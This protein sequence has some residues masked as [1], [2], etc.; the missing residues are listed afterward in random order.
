MVEGIE[1]H[2]L[3]AKWL[4]NSRNGSSLPGSE[5]TEISLDNGVR[6]LHLPLRKPR[7]VNPSDVNT[8]GQYGELQ[9]CPEGRV[10]GGR[11]HTWV[12]CPRE[13]SSRKDMG[14]KRCQ[15]LECY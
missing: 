9:V 6:Q 8:G 11:L 2:V 5:E 12:F 15:W 14:R 4:L 1:R 10:A 13:I 7:H 3:K